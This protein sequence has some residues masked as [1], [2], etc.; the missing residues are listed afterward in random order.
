WVESG[1][2]ARQPC[3]LRLPGVI[4]DVGA[5][6]CPPPRVWGLVQ[7]RDALGLHAYSTRTLP[8]SALVADCN[9]PHLAVSISIVLTEP[10]EGALLILTRQNSAFCR[11]FSSYAVSI[12]SPRRWR[13]TLR[14]SRAGQRE[15]GTSGRWQA[16]AAG[17]G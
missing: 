17:R 9:L 6:R 13:R 14:L 3:L 11:V 7:C 1:L 16:S 4:K 8:G 12:V 5:H 15:R 2:K 10:R